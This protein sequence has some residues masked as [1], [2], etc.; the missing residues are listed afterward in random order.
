M[1]QPL[2]LLEKDLSKQKVE[3]K[4]TFKKSCIQKEKNKKK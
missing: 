3:Q 1:K 2:N 4:T